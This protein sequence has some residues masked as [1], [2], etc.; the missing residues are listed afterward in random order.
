MRLLNR[1]Y[2]FSC[3]AGLL[4]AYLLF[5]S[6]SCAS[7]GS[8]KN[9]PQGLSTALK[10]FNTTI[11][12]GDYKTA[13]A[14]FPPAQQA[15]F[16]EIAEEFTRKVR[17]VDFEIRQGFIEPESQTGI[18]IL[19]FRYYYTNDPNLRTRTIQ[20]KWVYLD[21]PKGWRVSDDGLAGLLKPKE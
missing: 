16:W 15:R 2:L 20:Q 14:F 5:C 9:S 19:S 6:L 10:A 7:Y 17:I 12:W 8:Q 21:Q 4:I 1:E 13:A 3:R 11:R 18:G